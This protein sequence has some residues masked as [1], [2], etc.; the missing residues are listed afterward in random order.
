M[1]GVVVVDDGHVQ[2]LKR[3]EAVQL[4]RWVYGGQFILVGSQGSVD[5]RTQRMLA[6]PQHHGHRRL[7]IA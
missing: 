2:S 1:P 7:P 4:L 5:E 6:A 3:R